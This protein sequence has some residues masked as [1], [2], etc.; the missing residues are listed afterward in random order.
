MENQFDNYCSLKNVRTQN[1]LLSNGCNVFVVSFPA[2][3]CKNLNERWRIEL[4]KDFYLLRSGRFWWKTFAWVVLMQKIFERLNAPLR[5]V[6][7]PLPVNELDLSPALFRRQ[8]QNAA[9][10][11]PL[12]SFVLHCLSWSRPLLLSCNTTPHGGEVVCTCPRGEARR[13][14]TA[15]HLALTAACLLCGRW[16]AEGPYIC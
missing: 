6:G 14:P 15:Y 8:Q 13:N 16:E 1:Q 11:R 10:K 9:D 7:K 4:I 12:L 3:A 5:T 2:T